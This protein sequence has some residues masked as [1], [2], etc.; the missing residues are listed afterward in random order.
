MLSF[1]QEKRGQKVEERK[2]KRSAT[3]SSK[4]FTEKRKEEQEWTLLEIQLVPTLG[5]RDEFQ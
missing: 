3:G 5:S 2:G 4:Q 1:L